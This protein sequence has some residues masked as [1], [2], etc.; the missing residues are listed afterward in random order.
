MNLISLSRVLA[1][2]ETN[3]PDGASVVWDFIRDG[4]YF[5]RDGSEVLFVPAFELEDD[6]ALKFLRRSVKGRHR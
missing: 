5:E 2:T 1:G 6:T 4:I 3:I